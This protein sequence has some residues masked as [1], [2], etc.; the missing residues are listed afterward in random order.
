MLASTTGTEVVVRDLAL[1]LKQRGHQP[2]VYSPK[3][4]PMAE[5]IRAEGV[6]VVS[7]LRAIT[8]KPDIIHGH[9]HPQAM[10]ALMFFPE[11][12]GVFV[13]HDALAWH[14]EAPIF[15]RI[16]RYV[17]VDRRCSKRLLAQAAVPPERVQVI[18]NA[19]D[20]Q[21]FRQRGPLPSHPRRALIFSN[22]PNSTHVPAV[23]QACARTGLQV[24]VFGHHRSQANFE[25]EKVLREYDLVFAKAR[26]AIEAMAS[27]AAVVLCDAGG[28][29][30]MV[31][32]GEFDN[33]RALNFGGGTLVKPLDPSLIAAQ[34]ERYDADDA[35]AVCRRVRSAA[36]LNDA[37]SQWLALYEEVVAEYSGASISPAEEGSAASAYLVRWGWSGRIAW[38]LEQ[39]RKLQ[40]LP[41][42]GPMLE[43]TA[44]RALRRLASSR[45]AG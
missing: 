31:S 12:P 25:P 22:F 24:D 35:A 33:L 23:R 36:D 19:I 13:C 40:R 9:H 4:G 38:E 34:I 14:D 43:N 1:G 18:L 8:E 41:V 11:V 29:G 42:V 6:P 27:G 45:V 3:L 37:L 7:E 15:P 30:P 10:A 16:L 21:R 28:V 26:C 39:L 2:I 20:L 44:R 32:A 5:R 17:A